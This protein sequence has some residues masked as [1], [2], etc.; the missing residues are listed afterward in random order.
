MTL[1]QGDGNADSKDWVTFSFEPDA[2]KNG[3]DWGTHS[4]T[5]YFAFGHEFAT[6]GTKNNRKTGETARIWGID[7]V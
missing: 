1:I 5:S 3:G 6:H 7:C 4:S 2:A